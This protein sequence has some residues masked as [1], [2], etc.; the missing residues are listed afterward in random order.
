MKKN[1]LM[2]PIILL[3][4]ITLI[5][6]L[7]ILIISTHKA[8]TLGL[9]SE[10]SESS[11]LYKLNTSA[12]MAL[13][14]DSVEKISNKASVMV[15]GQVTDTKTLTINNNDTPQVIT[16]VK[17]AVKYDYKGAIQEGQE[18]QFVQH[19]G[20]VK[21]K[22]LEIPPKDFDNENT[23]NPESLVNCTFNDVEVSKIGDE[24]LF[25][26]VPILDDFYNLNLSEIYYITVGDYQGRFDLDTTQNTYI[27]QEPTSLKNAMKD[28]KLKAKGNVPIKEIISIP[29][30]DVNLKEI[31]SR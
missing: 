22:D 27:R 29:N 30:N 19:G 4:I 14:L 18:I 5:I 16:L 10:P 6:I 17:I 15:K 26:G 3:G 28:G 12:D 31:G 7:L 11:E 20:I 24:I 9:D 1:S 2:K 13:N 8:N 23:P 25:F 21:V